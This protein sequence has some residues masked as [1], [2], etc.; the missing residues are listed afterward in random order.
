MSTNTYIGY[1][2]AVAVVDQAV[3]HTT[4]DRSELLR[5]V[6]ALVLWS[7]ANS[8]AIELEKV[9]ARDNIVA[10]IE[11]GLTGFGQGTRTNRRS[12][13]LR[14]AEALLEPSLAPRALPA[15]A[16]SDPTMPYTEEEQAALLEWARKEKRARRGDDAMVLLALG[17]GAG[18]SAQEVMNVRAGDVEVTDG[19]VMVYVREGRVRVVPVLRRWET[20]L[21]RRA[22]ALK[23][24]EYLFKPGRDGAGKNLIS[25]FVA[26]A[27]V[28]GV[29]A[30]TQR[31]R[32]TWLVQQMAACTPLPELIDAAGV[33]SLEA[34]TRYLGFVERKATLD[35]VAK[36]RAA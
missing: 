5:A 21:G 6:S 26:K 11:G 36:L 9:F 24:E 1:E 25:N 7:N 31:M 15:L 35:V 14:V 13:L 10:H 32:S 33:D 16:A 19:A 20:A 17:F 8:V 4:Y 2:F 34:L 27:R 18:L 30:Q 22:A 12:Q 3:A 28:D 29:H 23:A